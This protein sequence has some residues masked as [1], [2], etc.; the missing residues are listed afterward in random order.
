MRKTSKERMTVPEQ[1]EVI[2]E[3]ICDGYCKYPQM[4]PQGMTRKEYDSYLE[5]ICGRCPLTDLKTYE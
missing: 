4:R 2:R 3:K 1:L 5:E